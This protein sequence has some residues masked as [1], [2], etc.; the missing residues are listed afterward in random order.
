MTFGQIRTVFQ[1][2]LGVVFLL[3]IAFTAYL[4]ITSWGGASWVFSSAVSVV[5]GGLALVRERQKLW[6]AIAGLAVTGIAVAVSLATA[7]DLPQEP[8]PI[9]ALALAVLVGSAIRTLPIGPAAGIAAGG[10]VVVGVTWFDG[11]GSVTVLATVGMI[12]ALVLGPI[13]RSLDRSRRTGA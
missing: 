4:L 9:T 12:V 5:V 8:A 1:L 2:G 3:G 7:D 6:A 11:S 13:L 10:L